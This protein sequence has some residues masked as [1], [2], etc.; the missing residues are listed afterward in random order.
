MTIFRELRS[1]VTEDGRT[2]LK[3]PSGTLS[4]AEAISVV[5]N[6]LALA[7]HFGDGE[8]S[9]EDVAGGLTGAV[10]QDPVADKVVWQEY[11]EAVVREARRLGCA[12]PGLPGAVTHTVFGIRHHGPG[13]ARTLERALAQL[14]PDTI[15]IEGPP[16]ADAL[17]ALASNEDMAPPVALLAYV[18][19]EPGPRRLLALRALLARVARDPL[20]ARPRRP[21][22]LQRPAGRELAGAAPGARSAPEG[23]RGPARRA[24]GDR[25]PR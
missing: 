17:L 16:E 7:T 2:K 19:D 24:R 21:R 1:G 14:E 5:T 8:L 6:G 9:P 3:S 22:A 11:L 25:R 4:T 18:P 20:R 12:V 23:P 15:L 10:V 13:S